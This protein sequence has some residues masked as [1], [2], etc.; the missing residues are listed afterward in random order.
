MT[1]SCLLVTTF[2]WF[3][4][5]P[6]SNNTLGNLYRYLLLQA[7]PVHLGLRLG[8]HGG[9]VTLLSLFSLPILLLTPLKTVT[10]AELICVVSEAF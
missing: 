3:M 10:A 8:R 5:L 7:F 1:S 6:L 4:R 9:C 2:L